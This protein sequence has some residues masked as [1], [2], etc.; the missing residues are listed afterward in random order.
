[1]IS[2]KLIFPL[3]FIIVVIGLPAQSQAQSIIEREDFRR[4]EIVVEI[5]PGARIDAVNE[6]NGTATIERIR[7]TNFYRVRTPQI[8]REEKWRNRLQRDPEVLS[9]SLNLLVACPTNVFARATVAFPGDRAAPGRTRSDYVLQP[10]LFQLLNLYDAQLRSRGA[11][12]TIAVIDTGIDRS[13]PAFASNLWKDN[14][15]NGDLAL[16]GIDEDH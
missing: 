9:A 8:D 10:H 11:G 15:P 1:M 6:R 12:V 14:R 2:T 13:H 3:V 5:K 16:D 4:G 7:G